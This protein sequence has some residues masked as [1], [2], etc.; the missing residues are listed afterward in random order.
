MAKHMPVKMQEVSFCQQT[1]LHTCFR[2]QQP[3]R[4]GPTSLLQ[5]IRAIRR[6]RSEEQPCSPFTAFPT[7]QTCAQNANR[8][9]LMCWDTA[10]H[11]S[12][13]AVGHCIMTPIIVPTT[14]LWIAYTLLGTVRN[15]K[16][17]HSF[18]S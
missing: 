11:G 14:T 18:H 6:R 9:M 16:A 15:C 4:F 8:C 7:L 1:Q 5:G 12:C 10:V 3:S 2:K 13:I 17:V